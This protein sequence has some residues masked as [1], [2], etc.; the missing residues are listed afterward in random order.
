MFATLL[1]VTLF[2]A[3]AL[4]GAAA[5]DL[6][7]DTPQMTTCEPVDI[8]WSSTQGP[9]NL[10]MVAPGECDALVDLGD[11]D[12]TSV[13]WTPDVAPGTQLELSLLDANNE[14]AWSGTIT[15]QQGSNTSCVSSQAL[16]A[17]SSSASDASSVSITGTT[18]VVTGAATTEAASASASASSSIGPVGAVGNNGP[19]SNSNGAMTHATSPVM[20]LSAIAGI[21]F[22]SL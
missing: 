19:L 11:Q 18:L 3:A 22:L 16:A 5:Q 9:Y 4:N 12:G 21:L 13:T 10:I 7:I 2:A 1:T 20:I 14:E 15:V 17:A 6:T 8:T